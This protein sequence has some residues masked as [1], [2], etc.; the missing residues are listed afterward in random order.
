[1]KKLLHKIT[2]NKKV[3]LIG[4][5]IL[6]LLAIVFMLTSND[7]S[8]D[9]AD[10]SRLCNSHDAAYIPGVVEAI[11]NNDQQAIATSLVS[12]KS[13]T[14]YDNAVSCRSVDALYRIMT[15]D[16]TGAEAIVSGLENDAFSGELVWQL[17]ELGLDRVTLRQRLA[18]LHQLE[19]DFDEPTTLLFTDD[20]D[21]NGDRVFD[22]SQAPEG[23][24]NE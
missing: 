15:G 7:S 20:E 23:A 19:V 13:Y 24:N 14:D 10:T 4:L 2:S 6:G 5:L 8:D 22:Y 11:K 16:T 17:N 3:I 18:Y 9:V 1:M 21:Y 12:M